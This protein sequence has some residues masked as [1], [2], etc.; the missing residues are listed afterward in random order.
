MTDS[1][2]LESLI[3]NNIAELKSLAD[4]NVS[5]R[6]YIK[7]SKK[8]S[9]AKYLTEYNHKQIDSEKY[10]M[11][12]SRVIT[13]NETYFSKKKCYPDKRIIC[14]GNMLFVNE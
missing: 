11:Y 6:E 2:L 7:Y 1:K 13:F 9:I 10:F 12:M 4:N 3:D 5:V 14:I 8:Y